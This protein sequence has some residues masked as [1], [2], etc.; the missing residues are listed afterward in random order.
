MSQSNYP[1]PVSHLVPRQALEGLR[2]R[3]V[4]EG[5]RAAAERGGWPALPVCLAGGP[6][7][8]LGGLARLLV[9]SNRYGTPAARSDH[10]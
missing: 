9:L 6:V 2:E 7:W 10:R 5:A 1:H 4:E 3:P 8:R